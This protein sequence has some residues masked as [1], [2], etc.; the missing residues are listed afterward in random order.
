MGSQ[1]IL[2]KWILLPFYL[3]IRL[4]MGRRKHIPKI[5]GFG[6]TVSSTYWLPTIWSA[7]EKPTGLISRYYLN[8]RQQPPTLSPPFLPTFL[9]NYISFL[10]EK[11]TEPFI[12][13]EISVFTHLVWSEWWIPN[14]SRPRRNGTSDT[15]GTKLHISFLSK[16]LDWWQKTWCKW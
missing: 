9:Q 3:L 4:L 14:D 12:D 16:S 13:S 15:D 8:C 11:Q 5:G 6:K 2:V 10:L 1:K 7:P